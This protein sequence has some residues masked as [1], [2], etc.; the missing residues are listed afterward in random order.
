MSKILNNLT[1][2]TIESFV[3]KRKENNLCA[4]IINVDL[5]ERG[6]F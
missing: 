1:Q 4:C 2:Q 3:K 5:L 6:F